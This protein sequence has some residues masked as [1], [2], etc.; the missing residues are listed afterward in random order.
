[1]L[2]LS[3]NH[4]RQASFSPDFLN[5]HTRRPIP[6]LCRRLKFPPHAADLRLLL[7]GSVHQARQRVPPVQRQARNPVSS[8]SD[9]PAVHSSDFSLATTTTTTILLRLLLAA[10]EDNALVV[11]VRQAG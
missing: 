8:R 5:A 4:N 7:R 10:L 1:M 11:K 3:A 2:P 9:K 6:D